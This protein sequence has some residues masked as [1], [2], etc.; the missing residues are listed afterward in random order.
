MSTP[1]GAGEARAFEAPPPPATFG[2]DGAPIEPALTRFLPRRRPGRY[3]VAAVVTATV[4]G[5]VALVVP[6][7][8]GASGPGGVGL[9]F[10]TIGTAAVGIVAIVWVW[11]WAGKRR[12][13]VPYARG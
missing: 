12:R 5:A 3:I 9:F 6:A 10:A 2:P 4:F 7:L 11:K 8:T 1:T 13:G